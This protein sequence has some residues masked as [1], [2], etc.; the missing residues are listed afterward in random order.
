MTTK[1]LSED[2]IGKGLGMMKDELDGGCIK[3]IYVLG[4]KQYGY[5]F[6]K[7]GQRIEKSVWAGYTRNGLSFS[8]I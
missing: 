5:W 2:M 3:E 1:K 6:V 4:I 8:E 7:D